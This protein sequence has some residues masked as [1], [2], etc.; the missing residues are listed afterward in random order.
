M[1]RLTTIARVV[2][3]PW[4]F[5][6]GE[7]LPNGVV[8][9]A[10]ILVPTSGHFQKLIATINQDGGRAQK[11]L[12]LAIVTNDFRDSL[13][14]IDLGELTYTVRGFG[15][16]SYES[17]SPLDQDSLKRWL[18]SL[19]VAEDSVD[20]ESADL[21]SL[22]KGLSAGGTLDLA[23]TL[24]HFRCSRVSTCHRPLGIREIIPLVTVV[25]VLLACL[26]VIRVRR[27][28][29]RSGGESER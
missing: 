25:I 2:L 6:V 4:F 18:R 11:T 8:P 16:E 15:S 22:A 17:P 29:A 20:A 9:N 27:A 13:M 3:L 5:T 1:T 26:Y 21:I 23:H 19:G 24:P 7:V 10:R 14:R 12:C 28:G